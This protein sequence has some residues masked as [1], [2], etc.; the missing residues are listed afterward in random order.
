MYVIADCIICI[1]TPEMF[2][3]SKCES[4]YIE[5][6]P[7]SPSSSRPPHSRS[8]TPCDSFHENGICLVS[9]VHRSR[10]SLA[11]VIRSR[12]SSSVSPS[13]HIHL[14]RDPAL[15]TARSSTPHHSRYLTA[16][17]SP[18]R[19]H[20]RVALALR[21]MHCARN[22]SRRVYPHRTPPC[23]PLQLHPNSRGMGAARGL[24]AH[25]LEP[26]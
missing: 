7:T 24:E 15:K 13:S 22:L 25:C 26:P 10:R 1:Y 17:R 3:R 19:R 18:L 4:V 20:R 14:V 2:K 6:D 8:S 12:S 16:A 9:A 11:V 23:P 5:N 21:R